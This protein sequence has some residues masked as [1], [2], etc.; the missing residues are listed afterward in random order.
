MSIDVEEWFQVEN[1][2]RSIRRDTWKGR[3]LRAERTMER[4]LPL[5]ADANVRA[6]CF[7]LGWVAERSP[8]LVRRIAEAGHEIGS[9]GY[10]H[11]LLSELTPATFRADVRRSKAVLEDL[12]NRPVVGYRAPSFSMT[13]WALPILRDLG[14][15]YDS[16][17]FPITFSHRRYGKLRTAGDA[18]SR[19]TDHDGIAEISLSC[20]RVGRRALPWAGGGYFRVIPYP[21]F[22]YGVRRILRSGEPYVFYLHPW[23][24]D[25]EQPRVPGLRSTER[26]RH[27]INLERT[28]ARWAALLRDFAWMPIRDLVVHEERRARTVGSQ[29]GIPS[30][31][32]ES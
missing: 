14:F 13:D 7:V 6:T 18:P 23:E 5:M 24:L 20:L 2:R 16:S 3:E 15:R 32:V 26:L 19:P 1:L 10:G 11:E 21:V 12:V 28:E 25:A 22:R 31:S 27:Y 30:V 9:H 29:G 4:M 17:Y 8:G